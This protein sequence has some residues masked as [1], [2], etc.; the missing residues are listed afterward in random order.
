MPRTRAPKIVDIRDQLPVHETRRFARRKLSD[1]RGVVYHHLAGD[2][3]VDGV[4]R[5]HVSEDCHISPGKG[6]PG[7]VYTFFV[8]KDGT[9]YLCNDLENVTWA[10]GGGT[11]PIPQARANVQF[12]SVG[13]RG[14]FSSKGHK[15]KNKPTEQQLDV[16]RRLWFHLK[17]QLDLSEDMLFGHYDFGKA[18]CPGDDIAKVIETVC[19]EGLQ[20][21]PNLPRSI[22]DWQKGLVRL[23]HD[24]GTY[25]PKKDGVDGSWGKASQEALDLFVGHEDAKRGVDE[26][27]ALATALA[28]LPPPK[29]QKMKA[30]KKAKKDKVEE[31]KAEA[32]PPKEG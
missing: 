9:V 18:A 19:A 12:V 30:K 16:A 32:E 14:D 27:V 23:G 29:K 28:K 15:G 24:L 1:I 3:P 11:V 13:F 10:Q 8:E 31:K 2:F 26:S 6:C 17:D 20:V 22:E 7:I 5:Y 25:G 4:A 21:K